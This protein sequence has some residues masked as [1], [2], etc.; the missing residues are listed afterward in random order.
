MTRLKLSEKEKTEINRNMSKNEMEHTKHFIDHNDT[1]QPQ[2][3]HQEIMF[4]IESTNDIV[5][6]LVQLIEYI[7]PKS[8]KDFKA[9]KKR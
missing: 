7:F 9:G 2:T 3:P 1:P 6:E 4:C 8:Y 5:S